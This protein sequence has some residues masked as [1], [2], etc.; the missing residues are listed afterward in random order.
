MAVSA[1][2]AEWIEIIVQC[3][4]NITRGVSALAAEWIEIL[5]EDIKN[6]GIL[7]PPSRRS[8]LK[9]QIAM[10]LNRVSDVSA[11]AAE[12]IEISTSLATDFIRK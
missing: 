10:E 3:V 12:W 8:G 4:Q 6:V 2:A 5:P 9:S 7:S 11:L 1:L